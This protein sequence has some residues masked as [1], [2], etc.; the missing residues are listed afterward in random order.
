MEKRLLNVDVNYESIGVIKVTKDK[1]PIAFQ[2]KIEELKAQG[3]DDD[4]IKSFDI[5]LE[6]YYEQDNGLFAVESDAVENGAQIVSP[7][8][9]RAYHDANFPNDEFMPTL[10]SLVDEEDNSVLPIGYVNNVVEDDVPERLVSLIERMYL[11]NPL[12]KK[13]Y[14]QFENRNELIENVMDFL[15]DPYNTLVEF[16]FNDTTY[17][18]KHDMIIAL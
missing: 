3:F 5:E 18:L 4:S 10:L 13:E 16:H 11:N 8:S 9:G 15:Q 14:K 17:T 1:F 12:N 7:Y 6:I 2:N